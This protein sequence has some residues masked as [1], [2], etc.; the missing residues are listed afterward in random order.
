MFRCGLEAEDGKGLAGGLA[1]HASLTVANLLH[2]NFDKEMAT[3][4]TK[5]AAEKKLSLIHI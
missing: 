2:N 4:L 1:V 3:M 5:V